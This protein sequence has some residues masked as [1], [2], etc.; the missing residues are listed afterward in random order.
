MLIK[1]QFFTGTIL[2][3]KHK[4]VFEF[5][6]SLSMYADHTKKKHGFYVYDFSI[7]DLMHKVMG[8][9]RT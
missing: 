1:I 5:S 2:L 7:Q 4:I 6:T 3:I 8:G 9:E